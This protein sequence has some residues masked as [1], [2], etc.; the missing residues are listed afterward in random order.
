M[1]NPVVF[2]VCVELCIYHPNPFSEPYPE[3]GHRF[4]EG[5]AVTASPLMTSLTTEGWAVG[6]TTATGLLSVGPTG[7]SCGF[8]R[9]ARQPSLARLPDTMCFLQSREVYL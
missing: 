1:C 7:K 2:I 5:G 6:A 8:F 4:R 3:A 9:G